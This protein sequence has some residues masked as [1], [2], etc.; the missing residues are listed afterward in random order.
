MLGACRSS[1]AV[2]PQAVLAPGRRLSDRRQGRDGRD[3]ANGRRNT[4][5]TIGTFSTSENG[6]A[7]TVRTLNVNVKVTFVPNDKTSSKGPDYRVLAGH[8][9]LDQA[10]A[11]TSTADRPVP[12]VTPYDHS[13]PADPYPP[14]VP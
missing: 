4:M 11:K 1:T 8:S 13:T 6:Y 3:L 5:S 9:E 12:S 14:P 7:G 10:W 2:R